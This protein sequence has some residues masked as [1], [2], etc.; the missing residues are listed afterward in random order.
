MKLRILFSSVALLLIPFS[1]NAATVSPATLDLQ[2]SKGETISSTFTVINTSAAEQKYFLDTL[3]F[4]PHDE[5]GTPQFLEKDKSSAFTKWIQFSSE[6]ITVP[7]RS[8]VD[9]PFEI[10]VPSDVAAGNQEVAI[11]I[12]SAP[13]DIVATNGAIIEAKT[14]LL[15]F[16]TI[17]GETIKQAALLDFIDSV[18]S[19]ARS[20]LSGNFSYRIQ[21]QGNVYAIPV[22]TIQF[23]DLFGR[24]LLKMDANEMKGRI[25][26]GSTRKFEVRVDVKQNG[27]LDQIKNQMQ[28]FAIGPITS[29][30]SIELGD[31]FEP[32][33]AQTTFWYVPYQM[34]GAILFDLLC[35]FLLYHLFSKTVT[36]KH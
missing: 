21:N 24:V 18:G 36:K 19:N 1:M 6:Q 34:I 31:G 12:S 20:E 27:L 2:A 26:P 13:S 16:L 22:G 14:A 33:Y 23:K 3:G 35:L 28:T 11:T 5:S 17:K 8:K 15:V 25:L 29:E 30:L 9:V 10:I 32:I 4:K 7:A